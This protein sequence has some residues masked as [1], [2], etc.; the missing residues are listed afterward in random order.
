MRQLLKP[1][2]A[3]ALRILAWVTPAPLVVSRTVAGHV[4]PV[5]AAEQPTLEIRGHTMNPSAAPRS[6]VSPLLTRAVKQAQQRHL[7]RIQ[8][9]EQYVLKPPKFERAYAR[10]QIVARTAEFGERGQHL[11]RRLDDVE[12]T[13][14]GTRISAR[15]DR[16]TLLS[17]R[18]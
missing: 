15:S 9:V 6:Q 17:D 16:R 12:Q 4:L 10:S 11:D 14:S 5:L 2:G 13:V 18:R 1:D 7:L 3:R 8:T